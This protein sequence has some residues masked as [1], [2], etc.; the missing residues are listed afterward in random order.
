MK[1][2]VI[3]PITVS[4]HQAISQSMEVAKSPQQIKFTM[5]QPLYVAQDFLIFQEFVLLAKVTKSTIQQLKHADVLK[6]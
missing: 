6:I 4:V 5:G 3:Q 2:I 1:F